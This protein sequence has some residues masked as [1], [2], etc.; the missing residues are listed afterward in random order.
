MWHPAGKSSDV[1][2][3]SAKSIEVA[4]KK[5]ALFHVGGKFYALADHCLHRGG[6][7]GLGHVEGG[8]VTCPWH[9]WV[10]EVKT[11]KCLTMEGAKQA[12]FPVKV[13]KGELYVDL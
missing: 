2:K 10:F 13:E 9:G 11:G 12:S 7:L 8:R 4:G 5:L 3:E 1:P 6:Q